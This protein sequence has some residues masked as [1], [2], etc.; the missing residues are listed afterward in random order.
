[1]FAALD[2][3]Q[4]RWIRVVATAPDRNDEL[5]VPSS[6]ED[7]AARIQIF[8]SKTWLDELAR[9]M[10]AR[11]QRKGHPVTELSVELWRS[12]YEPRTLQATARRLAVH[13]IEVQ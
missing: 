12:D 6:L 7:L 8:P 9:R 2:G 11:E 3:S 1:M 13:R 4:H 5:N 10:A